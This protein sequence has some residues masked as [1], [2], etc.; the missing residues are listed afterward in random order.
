MISPKEPLKTIPKPLTPNKPTETKVGFLR[1]LADFG[2]YLFNKKSSA[3]HLSKDIMALE[4]DRAKARTAELLRQQAEDDQ[5][6]LE[7]Q[8]KL[9]E[10]L[11]IFADKKQ[12]AQSEAEHNKRL[13]HLQS[14][15]TA[16]A[17]AMPKPIPAY[18]GRPVPPKPIMPV[19]A[20]PLAPKP[21]APTPIKVMP[22]MPS[23][24]PVKPSVVPALPLAPNK[25]QAPTALSKNDLNAKKQKAAK[26]LLD[27]RLKQAKDILKS[28]IENRRWNPY[29]LVQVNLIKEQQAMFFDWKHKLL[30]LLFFMILGALIVVLVYGYLLVYE[31]RTT[32]LNQPVYVGLTKLDKEIARVEIEIKSKVLPLNDRLKFVG[33]MLDNHIY[34]NNFFKFLED[35][36]LQDVYYIDGIN[37]SLRGNTAQNDNTFEIMTVARNFTTISNQNQIFLN[38]N[39]ITQVEMGNQQDLVNASSSLA[40]MANL[41][42]DYYNAKRFKYRLKIS[43]DMFIIKEAVV[44]PK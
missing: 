8:S 29:R 7:R 12:R 15:P 27:E 1:L 24:T 20:P 40:D 41:P 35:Q 38:S 17:I 22:V 9:A 10:E 39:L 42:K 44:E 3:S 14:Q 25:P 2:T 13:A 26:Q 34:W 4:A 36:T 23:P 33:Y 16:S 11:K 18:A 19:T 6:K 30:S 32:D 43:P 31:K 28:Q 37:A 5:L 21:L